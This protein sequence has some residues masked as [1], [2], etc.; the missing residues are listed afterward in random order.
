MRHWLSV[1]ILA[2]HG[3]GEEVSDLGMI[4]SLGIYD[5]TVQAVALK[6]RFISYAPS[7]TLARLRSKTSK[8]SLLAQKSLMIIMKRQFGRMWI[9]GFWLQS[10]NWI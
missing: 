7:V 8:V 3:A 1:H 5:F 6:L 4:G 10:R 9:Q 2:V